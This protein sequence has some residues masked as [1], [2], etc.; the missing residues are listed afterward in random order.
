MAFKL[1]ILGG[2]CMAHNM[3]MLVSMTLAWMQGHSGSA[4]EKNQRLMISTCKP[5]IS[6]ELAT[7][8]GY[9]ISIELATTVGYVLHDLGSD[10]E[11]NY[12]A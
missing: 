10:F 3:L 1:G 8:V 2:L 7:T 5:V 9:I 4:E 6:I 12:M 11:N